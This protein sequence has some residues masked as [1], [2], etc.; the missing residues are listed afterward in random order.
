MPDP[1]DRPGE[2]DALDGRISRSAWARSSTA[3]ARST[4]RWPRPRSR[5]ARAC[6]TASSSGA[7]SPTRKARSCRRATGASISS[8]GW[9]RWSQ[10]AHAHGLP[11]IY[12]GCGNVKAIFPD[13]I[14][15]GIDAY[16]PLEA[17]AGMDVVELRRQYGHRIGFCGNSDIQV[18]ESG[19]RA[20]DP[21]R[22]AAQAQRRQGRRL[23]L[24]VR[25]LRQQRR[26]R[27]YL[28]LHREAGART[29]EIPHPTRRI[30]GSSVTDNAGSFRHPTL[31]S[32]AL[33][34]RRRE[35]GLVGRGTLPH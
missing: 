8:R 6:S 12:H 28:R 16:N 15:M 9:R 26:L 30:R 33:Y 34:Q 22:G 11:V 32:R 10:R 31:A 17:K 5:P 29:R 3:S 20:G 7:T 27:P 4:S 2:H 35:N 24:P 25:P 13:Y 21:P 19:D 23:H 1:A 14:E 18:W